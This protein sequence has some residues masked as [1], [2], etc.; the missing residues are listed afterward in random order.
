MSNNK[1]EHVNM[2]DVFGTHLKGYMRL[3]ICRIQY[4]PVKLNGARMQNEE[5]E[6]AK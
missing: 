6:V 1:C 5:Q 2:C 4:I 3:L